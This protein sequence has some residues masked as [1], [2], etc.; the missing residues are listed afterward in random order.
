MA[1]NTS[2]RAQK[3]VGLEAHPATRGGV[4]VTSQEG[5][6]LFE[7]VFVDLSAGVALLQDLLK[8]VLIGAGWRTERA[9]D[10]CADAESSEDE[11][12]E[13]EPIERG[14]DMIWALLKIRGH[15]SSLLSKLTLTLF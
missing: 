3:R 10:Q 1:K 11:D 9:Q 13:H 12:H 14:R 7:F 4:D 15:D 6:L 2:N 8:V 5:E